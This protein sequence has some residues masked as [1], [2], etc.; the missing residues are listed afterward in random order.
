[1]GSVYKSYPLK[2]PRTV[3][4]LIPKKQ[5]GGVLSYQFV[6]ENL[7]Q[8]VRFAALSY[9]WGDPVK[10]G[11]LMLEGERKGVTRNLL[12][13]L[14]KLDKILGQ[15]DSRSSEPLPLWIDQLCINQ[16]D[17]EERGSQVALMGDI[18][19]CAM[20]VYVC[21]GDSNTAV[22]AAYVVTSVF[23]R[24]K[25]DAA[26][27]FTIDDIPYISTD[28]LMSYNQLNWSALKEMML[29]SWFSRAWVV[30]EVGLAKHAIVLY[31]DY[32]FEW[33]SLMTVLGWLSYPGSRLRQIHKISGWAV[34]QLWV[35]FDPKGRIQ[36]NHFPAYDF[37]DILS[38]AACSYKATDSRDYI[39]S[40][41]GHPSSRLPPLRVELQ[42]PLIEPNYTTSVASVFI[43][44]AIAWLERSRQ[45]YLFSCVNHKQLPPPYAGCSSSH[46]NRLEIPSWCPRW[47][48]LP[49]GGSRLDIETDKR[50]Y[51][52]SASTEFGF[53]RLPE[54]RLEVRAILYD[55]I[56]ETFAALK[57]LP[58]PVVVDAKSARV[59][60]CSASE[61][62]TALKLSSLCGSILE[63][64]GK[65]S[66]S[67][68]LKEQSIQDAIFVFAS[69]V[70][71]GD[72]QGEDVS[73]HKARQLANFK[74]SLVQAQ[75]SYALVEETAPSLFEIVFNLLRAYCERLGCRI[76]TADDPSGFLQVAETKMASRRLFLSD[77]GHIGLGPEI[78]VPGDVCCVISGANVPYIVRPL[79]SAANLLVGECYVQDIM[80]GE[81]IRDYGKFEYE[82]RDIVLE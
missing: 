16:D 58:V 46:T 59:S 50:W 81:V 45:A 80:H 3:R 13:A 36:T 75:R 27:Y 38:H 51:N 49:L 69:T 53:R 28:E 30:Q 9:V 33:Q 7:D 39:F 22:D 26:Q 44:F 1:M 29:V 21:L 31:G 34:H 42:S 70:H 74:A 17:L 15:D 72:W 18:Y 23:D 40:L 25:L 66:S 60:I 62:E 6:V 32:H 67:N 79:G 73:L 19:S 11:S 20:H 41:L 5:E 12:D 65:Q 63:S 2:A 37:L 52:T 61:I 47:D 8:N 64:M 43:Q 24:I 68:P 56:F 71:A 82:W 10:S 4:F 55:T 78:I 76:S 48:F 54:D 57:D 77:Q 14:K 35:S